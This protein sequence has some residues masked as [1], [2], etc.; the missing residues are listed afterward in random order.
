MPRVGLYTI[1]DYVN[2]GNRLQ[3]YAGQEILK[4]LGCDVESII[5]EPHIVHDTA[6]EYNKKRLINA[7]SQNPFALIKRIG[8]K[9]RER[10]NKHLLAEC[11]K[12]KDIAFRAFSKKYIV[13]TDFVIKNNEVPNDIDLRYDYCVVGSDQIWNPNIRYGAPYDFLSFVSP[14]KRIAFAP[15]FGVSQI[16]EKYKEQ[17]SKYLKA[18][19][20]LSVREDKGA[21]IIRTLSGREAQVLVDP[22]LVLTKQQWLA[23]AKPAAQKPAGKY[24]LT[25]F[26]GEVSTKR[27]KVLRKI[28][29]IKNLEI[30]QMNSLA[31][32]KRFDADPAEFIDYMRNASIICTDSFHSCIFSIIFERPFVVFNREGRSAKMSSRLDTLLGKLNL[33]HRWLHNIKNDADYF[34]VDFGHVP[35]IVE[36][37]RRVFYNYLRTAMKIE[38]KVLVSS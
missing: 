22:T 3:N 5:N 11:K 7:L 30:V 15:S 31:D 16:P 33:Q 9:Y 17:Y 29:T 13:E 32:Y 25:Y 10:K 35:A 26:I 37:E 24:L 21:E 2:Y 14:E 18:M 27:M 20:H 4:T 23:I 36:N 19:A 8:V 38:K 1:T 34:K 12:R 6:I 28:A